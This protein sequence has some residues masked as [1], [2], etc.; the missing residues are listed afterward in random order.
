MLRQQVHSWQWK[1]L[2]Q[3]EIDGTNNIP[4]NKN[5]SYPLQTVGPTLIIEKLYFCIITFYSL[6]KYLD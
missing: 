3:F 6:L 5:Q 4:L 2:K 1:F